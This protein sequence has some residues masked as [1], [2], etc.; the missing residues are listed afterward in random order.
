[1]NVVEAVCLTYGLGVTLMLVG[2][3]LSRYVGVRP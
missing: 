1:M 2:F 3:L